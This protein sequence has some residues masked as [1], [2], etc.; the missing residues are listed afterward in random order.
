MARCVFDAVAGWSMHLT[1]LLTFTAASNKCRIRGNTQAVVHH[2]WLRPDNGKE[3]SVNL[4]KILAGS[5]GSKL[6]PI[7]FLPQRL[8]KCGA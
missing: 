2:G 1:L 7:A 4:V 8:Q 3:V 5:C 6:Q